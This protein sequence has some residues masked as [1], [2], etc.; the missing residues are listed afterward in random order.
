VA[1]KRYPK[2]HPKGGQFMPKGGGSGYSRKE[3][4]FARVFATKTSDAKKMK[5]A[6]AIAG[7]DFPLTRNAIAASIVRSRKI[8][9]T[10]AAKARRLA[11]RRAWRA[12]AKGK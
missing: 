10:R 3:R 1:Q 11:L 4:A 2:G 5:K 9:A 6:E 7:G 8:R 12:N